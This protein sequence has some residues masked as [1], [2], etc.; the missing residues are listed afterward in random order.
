[1]LFFPQHGNRLANKS[2]VSIEGPANAGQRFR[3]HLRLTVTHNANSFIHYTNR[4][5]SWQTGNL[6]RSGFSRATTGLREQPLRGNKNQGYR[7]HRPLPPKRIAICTGVRDR[8][9]WRLPPLKK[10]HASHNKTARP[11]NNSQKEVRA[12]LATKPQP[13]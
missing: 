2:S 7:K 6:S 3:D 11:D 13:L 5:T 10:G 9:G 1:M 4:V 8:R 12:G